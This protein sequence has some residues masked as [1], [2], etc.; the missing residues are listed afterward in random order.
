MMTELQKKQSQTLCSALDV[1]D[2]APNEV[3]GLGRVLKK[4]VTEDA[5]CKGDA[6]L[7]ILKIIGVPDTPDTRR[8]AA[9]L[10]TFGE[11]EESAIREL[12]TMSELFSKM[13]P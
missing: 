10:Y 8:T 4:V 3:I 12:R 11:A 7:D 1:S 6:V 2:I 9:I 13:L 5:Y